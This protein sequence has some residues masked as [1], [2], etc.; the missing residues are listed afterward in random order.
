MSHEA[1]VI[2]VF[3]AGVV[4]I[5]GH[6]IYSLRGASIEKKVREHMEEAREFAMLKQRHQTHL[7]QQ[8][9]QMMAQQN[10][11]QAPWMNVGH[12]STTKHLDVYERTQL[13]LVQLQTLFLAGELE[14][15]ELLNATRMASS[16]DRE[17]LVV[18]E[19]I[20]KAK[21]LG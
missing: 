10:M 17:N 1:L 9:Q 3:A 19:E 16:I 20:I 21:L 15:Q 18:V 11:A 5:I 2:M 8:Q 13:A 12:T 4:S 6:A 7:Q 14:K